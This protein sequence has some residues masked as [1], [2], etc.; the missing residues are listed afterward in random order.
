MLWHYSCARCGEPLEVDWEWLREEVTCPRCHTTHYP[1]TPAEDHSAYVGTEAWPPELE[2]AVIA[3]RGTTCS[4]PGCFQDYSTLAHRV[5]PSASGRTSID[6]L[7]PL[8]ARHAGLMS[9]RPYDEWL[10]ELGTETPAPAPDFEITFTHGR[11]AEEEAAAPA[12]PAGGLYVQPLAASLTTPELPAGIRPVLAVPFLPGA[13]RRLKFDYGWGRQSDG[14]C[15]VLLLAW[16]DADPPDLRI[17]PDAPRCQCVGNVHHGTA[18][19]SG[20]GTLDLGLPEGAKD[21]WTAL[22]VVVDQGG[23]L[24]VRDYLLAALG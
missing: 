14:G 3:L 24:A 8:C 2:Q 23:Q 11:K 4:V 7:L 12:V 22:V 10:Q 1:P 18:G 15:R 16:P 17:L 5:P 19:Q 9:D 13:A 20:T 6:N 21:R